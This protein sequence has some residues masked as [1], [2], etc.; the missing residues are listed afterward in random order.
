MVMF[1]NEFLNSKDE[2]LLRFLPSNLNSKSGIC[3]CCEII[4]QCNLNSHKRD[5]YKVHDIIQVQLGTNFFNNPI[6]KIKE[7]EIPVYEV[8]YIILRQQFEGV[9]YLLLKQRDK[10]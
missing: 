4:T 10:I 6:K 9:H 1:K 2:K 5:F 3:D 7:K 8:K